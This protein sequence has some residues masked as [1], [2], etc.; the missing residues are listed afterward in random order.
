VPTADITASP[1]AAAEP[2]GAL[3]RERLAACVDRVDCDPVY[4]WDGEVVA[5]EKAVLLAETTDRQ[6]GALV[7]RA[8]EL[9]PYDAPCIERFGE[10]D[11]QAA[12]A[13]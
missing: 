2:A 5:D 12:L 3:V 10:A 1:E 4:R 9:H 7:D 11:I 8:V 13:A 6:H